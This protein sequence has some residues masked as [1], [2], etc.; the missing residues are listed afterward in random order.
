M[1]AIRRYG[2]LRKALLVGL[3]WAF[4]IAHCAGQ[5]ISIRVIDVRTGGA[6]S[7]KRIRVHQNWEGQIH[8]GDP[9]F[10][11]VREWLDLK[12][13]S[14]G[15]AKF[16][17]RSPLPKNLD[18]FLSVGW[19]TQ[20]SPSF[21]PV[22]DVLHSGVVAKNLCKSAPTSERNYVAKPGEI[23]VFTRYVTF[24]ERLKQFPG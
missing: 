21:F 4:S 18:V 6:V 22:G 12:A 19:W 14:D 17:L 11:H 24:G 3:S 10:L 5:E 7:G 16:S 23:V 13:G 15:V 2:P 8:E 20:C 9:R 1:I